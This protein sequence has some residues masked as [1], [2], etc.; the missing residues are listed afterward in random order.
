MN[1]NNNSIEVDDV[2]IADIIRKSYEEQ[3]LE[4]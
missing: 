1:D 4:K 3:F 2:Q